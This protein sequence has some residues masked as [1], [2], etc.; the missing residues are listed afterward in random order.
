MKKEEDEKERKMLS[1]NK[2]NIWKSKPVQLGLT[3]IL[4]FLLL[5]P[6]EFVQQLTFERKMRKNEVKHEIANKWG[7]EV[8]FYGPIL[9]VPYVKEYK[10]KKKNEAGE[11]YYDVETKSFMAYI[12]PNEYDVK[13]DIDASKKH[14]GI[15]DAVV[16]KGDFS[17]DGKF[18]LDNY[19]KYKVPKENFKWENAQL[20]FKTTNLKSIRNNIDVT[21]DNRNYQFQP[22]SAND[23]DNFKSLE[24]EDIDLSDT[25]KYKRYT[26]F[27]INVS[28][29]GTESI[30]FVP[31]GKTSTVTVHSNWSD[32][33]FNG[34]FLP[35]DKKITE[36]GFDA[37]WKVLHFNRPFSQTFSNDIP[38]LS[39]HSFG[40]ELMVT[41]DQYQQ[42][43][44][45]TKYGLLVIALTFL[46]F[47]MIQMINK[48]SFNIIE[49]AMIGLAMVLFYTLLLSITEHSTF[50]I[51]YLISAIATISLIS[52]YSF[53]LLKRLKLL[54]FVTTTMSLL[55]AYIFVIIQMESYALLSGSIGLFV[56]LSIV[57]YFSRKIDWQK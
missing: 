54:F 38:S 42:N 18:D 9:K 13:A 12:L 16:Y 55:Y 6:L 21:M 46:T 17:L 37:T 41:V 11:Y 3:V 14:R 56:I 43:E 40:L 49:Y 35:I 5:I 26:D 50:S 24:T 19:K 31:I 33:S 8:E 15:Y 39:E 34:G 7:E 1:E 52:I 32:P 10:R 48:L 25:S 30:H 29:N 47:F 4:I 27:N 2:E 44:R 23:S 36:E 53:S 20:I 28:Y 57:M 45:A 22:F 51:A